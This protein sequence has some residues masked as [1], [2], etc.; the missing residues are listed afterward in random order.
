MDKSLQTTLQLL[1]LSPKETKFYLSSF[2]L[3]PSSVNEI[4]RDAKLERSTGYLIFQDL[5]LKGFIQEDHRSY[6]KKVYTLDPK[7]L[8]RRLAAKQRQLK[9]QELELSENLPDL[10]AIYQ[11]SE[12]RPRAKVFEGN[13]GLLSIWE[14]ILSA[15]GEILLWTNQQTENTFFNLDAH[16]RFIKD[17]VK[18]NILI[19]VLAVN[20]TKGR[21]LIKLDSI[22]LRQTRLL[23]KNVSFSAETYIY[24]NKI[25]ILDYNKDIIGVIIES[26]PMTDSHR[27]IFAMT[28]SNA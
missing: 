19:R 18:K 13:S 27:A 14:D 8:I 21:Q 3:G 11:V 20:N 12:I 26:K 5:L 7:D 4:A 1:G 9:R 28:F 24:D 16:I 6:G 23:P 25:A 2:K 10:Q 17:R 22:Y 15:K